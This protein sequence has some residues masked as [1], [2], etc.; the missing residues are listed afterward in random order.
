VSSGGTELDAGTAHGTVVGEGGQE[1]IEAGGVASNSL[2]E[3][4]QSLLGV[5]V[6]LFGFA[7]IPAGA[8][9]IDSGGTAL[10][11]VVSGNQV[12]SSGGV[13]SGAELSGGVQNV[14]FGGIA[15]GTEVDSGG[16]E[17]VSSGGSAIGTS[18]NDLG[19]QDVFSGAIISNSQLVAGGTQNVEQGALVSGQTLDGGTQCLLG[20][21]AYG[22]TDGG[23]QV[24]ESTGVAYTT[25]IE[26]GGQQTIESNGYAGATTVDAG[27][28]CGPRHAM[29]LGR[30]HRA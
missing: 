5:G 17:N 24:I 1:I 22:T 19:T 7:G 3:P 16:I 23:Q 25:I 2:I 27:H 8:Q 28:L 20:G 26:S 12:V 21:T 18:V 13:A 4:G 15:S 29:G 9:I 14:D 30:R 10:D 11:A 6:A